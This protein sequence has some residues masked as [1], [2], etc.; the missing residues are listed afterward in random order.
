MPADD[1]KMRPAKALF[2]YSLIYLFGIFAAFL[3]DVLISRAFG[4]AGI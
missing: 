1:R 3:A 2:G 4:L